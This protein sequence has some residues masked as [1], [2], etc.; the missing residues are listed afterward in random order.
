LA[1]VT[2]LL[3]SQLE[4]EAGGKRRFELEAETVREALAKLPIADLLY[5]ER[6]TLRALV[7][8]FVDGADAREELDAPLAAGAE[9]RVV[10]A[11]A[12]G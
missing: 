11:I 5:D 6:G 10:A 9:I 1:S 2:V 8:V 4:R 7:H 3:P 12:G